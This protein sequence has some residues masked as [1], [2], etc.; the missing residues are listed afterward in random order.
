MV[1]W[2]FFRSDF[3]FSVSLNLESSEE[4]ALFDEV[5]FLSLESDLAISDV[6]FGLNCI[7]ALEAISGIL[8][9]ALHA[10]GF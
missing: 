5:E 2:K 9:M 7:V 3:T 1:L 6:L 4:I 10:I 8:A